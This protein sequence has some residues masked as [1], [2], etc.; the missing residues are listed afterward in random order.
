M[1]LYSPVVYEHAIRFY[2]ISIDIKTAYSVVLKYLAATSCALVY[3]ST[4]SDRSHYNARCPN[5]PIDRLPIHPTSMK[6]LQISGEG[7]TGCRGMSPGNI[8]PKPDYWLG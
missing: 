8:P 6:D 3:S 2:R 1:I 7:P 4:A 5:M